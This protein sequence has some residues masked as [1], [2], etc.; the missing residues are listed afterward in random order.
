MKKIIITASLLLAFATQASIV[1]KNDMYIPVRNSF[2][3]SM[4]IGV[5]DE[6]EFNKVIDSIEKIYSPIF[7]EKYESTLK[8]FRKWEDGT[9]NAYAKQSG[10]IWEVHMFGGLARHEATTPDGFMAVICHEIGHHIG[11]APK[12]NRW[13]VSSWASNEGQADYFATSKCLRKYFEKDSEETIKRY[14]SKAQGERLYAKKV[15]DKAN[16]SLL[17]SAICYRSALAGKSLAVLLGTLGGTPNVSFKI[18][19]NNVVTKTNDKHPKAQCR[20]D[21]YFQ[22]ALCDKDHNIFPSQK[23]AATGFC[24]RKDAYQVGIRP[25]CWLKPE[26][27]GL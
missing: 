13:G 19:D 15:C 24:N 3:K 4:L 23:D 18:V 25:L 20:L 21:T 12:I 27:H 17:E 2:E 11:G 10:K 22:G 9:V 5:S 14:E 1:P 16:S 8:I 26:Q 6:A 7:K